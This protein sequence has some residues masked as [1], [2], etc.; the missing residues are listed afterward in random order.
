MMV[1]I[2]DFGM[3]SCCDNCDMAIFDNHQDNDC[4]YYCSITNQS[5]SNDVFYYKRDVDCP[6]TEVE[7]N[8]NDSN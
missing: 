3:P 4:L 5:I 2:K 1:A 7:V 6:L 8:E